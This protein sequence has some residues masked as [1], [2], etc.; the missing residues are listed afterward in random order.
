MLKQGS[1]GE[2]AL[3]RAS[4]PPGAGVALASLARCQKMLAFAVMII[5]H[6][7]ML[8]LTWKL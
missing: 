2:K 8:S 1:L 4:L 5:I 3:L 6:Q 7:L